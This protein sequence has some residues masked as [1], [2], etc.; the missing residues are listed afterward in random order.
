LIKLPSYIEAIAHSTPSFQDWISL[1]AHTNTL[2]VGNRTNPKDESGETCA[3]KENKAT[4][5]KRFSLG[6]VAQWADAESIDLLRNQGRKEGS[7]LFCLL[8]VGST[9][10]LNGLDAHEVSQAASIEVVLI[11]DVGE[12]LIAAADRLKLGDTDA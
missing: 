2:S 11:R 12:C 10:H 3:R 1:T 4:C 5:F 6:P 9:E 7:I 8:L